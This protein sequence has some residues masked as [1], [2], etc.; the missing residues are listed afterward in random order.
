MPSIT[1]K[2]K[3]QLNDMFATYC[4]RNELNPKDKNV[5]K[6]FRAGYRIGHRVAR[7]RALSKAI[8]K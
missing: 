8:P 2:Q 3:K 6:A 4:E 1:R 7:T 5:I